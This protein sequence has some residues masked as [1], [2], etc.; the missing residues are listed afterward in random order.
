MLRRGKAPGQCLHRQRDRTLEDDAARILAPVVDP[1]LQLRGYYLPLGSTGE[2]A[3]RDLLLFRDGILL[4]V[5]SKAKPLRPVS[6][7]RGNVRKIES[8][9]KESIQAGYEQA[10]SVWRHISAS[11]NEV[12]FFDSNK[13]NRKELARLNPKDV[14]RIY[15]IIVVDSTYGLVG[16][17][18]TP[19]LVPNEEIGFP[20]VVNRDTLE[21]ITL[22][23]DSFE[24]LTEFLGWRRDEHGTV[25]DDDE[26]VIAGYFVR[27][28]PASLAKNHDLHLL[29][30]EYTDVFDFEYFKRKGISV[31]APPAG[32]DAPV[33]LSMRREGNRIIQEMG[34]KVVDSFELFGQGQGTDTVKARPG[35]R[36][37]P[38]VKLTNPDMPPTAP[39][40]VGRN[41][42]CPCGSG[43]KFK[44]CCMQKARQGLAF[45][46]GP[47]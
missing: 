7:H 30:P 17:D 8:D 11:E 14:R 43:V 44:R 29:V 10:C 12:V 2:L 39:R 19:W 16:T 18:L 45:D 47:V 31:E 15:A 21:L 36:R 5:E 4:L 13:T 38:G 9:V 34:G 32:S 46:D 28:G 20:W 22:K 6:R 37:R 24:K 35:N 23:I 1:V 41:D 3:E 33:I 27:H 40:H 26:A 25:V 42:P